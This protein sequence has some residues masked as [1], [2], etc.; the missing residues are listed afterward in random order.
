[1]AIV[2]LFPENGRTLDYRDSR[3]K[4][5]SM[6]LEYTEDCMTYCQDH[7]QEVDSKTSSECG[8]W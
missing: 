4:K 3:T 1:M 7:R 8:I 6:I 2:K 5:G